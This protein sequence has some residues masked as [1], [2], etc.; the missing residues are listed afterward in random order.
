MPDIVINKTIAF[1]GTAS[2]TTAYTMTGP[3][4]QVVS[5]SD[6]A[7]GT[8]IV[9]LVFDYTKVILAW[10]VVDND[11]GYQFVDGGSMNPTGLLY[12][13]ANTY[14]WDSFSNIDSPFLANNLTLEITAGSNPVNFTCYILSSL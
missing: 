11:C 14:Q 7:S 3:S 10:L 12:A 8:K 6:T 4:L 13:D 2:A 5:A 1:A 9:S